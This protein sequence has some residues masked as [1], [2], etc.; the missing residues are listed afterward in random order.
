MIVFG[1]YSFCIDEYKIEEVDL[2]FRFEEFD[3]IELRIQVIHLF[4][5]PLFPLKKS[6]VI[7]REGKK[8]KLDYNIQNQLN[9]SKGRRATPWY[10]YSWLVL[11]PI[12]FLLSSIFM[13]IDYEN[14][15]NSIIENKKKRID[16]KHEKIMNPSVGDYY[17]VY[18]VEYSNTIFK[19]IDFSDDSTTL[20]IPVVK[21]EL[22]W[23][24]DIVKYFD[25]DSNWFAIVKVSKT[26][27]DSACVKNPEN[28]G[29]F[30][31]APIPGIANGKLFKIDRV[32]RVVEF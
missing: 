4:M 5:I 9:K 2:P 1:T 14:T 16:Q 32:E 15:Q 24:D 28:M 19:V 10:A 21:K 31:G 20:K 27:L 17:V 25:D 11:T 29:Q 18:D 7:D 22:F 30:Q 6:W 3:E 12:V 8:L 26:S 23:G 13:T